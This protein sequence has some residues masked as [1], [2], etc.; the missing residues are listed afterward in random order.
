MTRQEDDVRKYLRRVLWS[1]SLGFLWLVLTL[2]IGT[3][4]DLLVPRNRIRTGN[5]IFYVWMVISLVALIR[6]YV[7]IWKK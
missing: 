2:A 6:F 3:Y 7:R 1:V 4:F 5:I